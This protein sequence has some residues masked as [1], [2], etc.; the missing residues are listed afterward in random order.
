MFGDEIGVL[1]QSVA[2]TLDLDD[3]GMVEQSVEQRRGDRGIAN[4]LRLPL[5]SMG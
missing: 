2:G 1:A 4:H 3:D 5:T